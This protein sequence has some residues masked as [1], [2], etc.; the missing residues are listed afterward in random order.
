MI[1]ALI[2]AINKTL[3]AQKLVIESTQTA[4]A[5]TNTI[6]YQVSPID[7]ST[8]GV[9]LSVQKLKNKLQMAA[10]Y[11]HIQRFTRG[12]SSTKTKHERKRK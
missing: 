2:T 11:V 4:N 12:Y 1:F 7:G 3:P 10:R 5:S 6:W 9:L 8:C